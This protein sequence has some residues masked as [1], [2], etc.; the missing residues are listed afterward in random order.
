M[1]RRFHEFRGRARGDGLLKNKSAPS[2]NFEGR[3]SVIVPAYNEEAVIAR[4]LRALTVNKN[5][6]QLE[7]LVA[8]NGCKDRTVEIA[9]TFEPYVTVL[10]TD[11]AGKVHALNLADQLAEAHPRVYMDADVTMTAD[12]II[13][14]CAPLETGRY[15]ATSP[16]VEHDVSRSSWLVRAYYRVWEQTP[17]FKAGM[18]GGGTYALSKEG[19][20]RFEKFPDIISDDGFVRSLFTDQER[21]VPLD[22]VVSVQVPRSLN[23]LLAIKRRSRLGYYE[24]RQKHPKRHE[25]LKNSFRAFFWNILIRP[26]LWISAMIYLWVQ[27]V[28]R[29]QAKKQLGKLGCYE[30]ER[31]LSSRAPESEIDEI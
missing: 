27:V 1:T 6:K 9:K 14:L 3:I 22:A 26:Q 28:S 24:L 29:S 17:Y 2:H 18:L 30:W 11:V 13:A 21:T 23:E 8:C 31:D 10:E 20:G 16:N 7:I 4:A 19:R 5:P 15:L 25:G 12:S